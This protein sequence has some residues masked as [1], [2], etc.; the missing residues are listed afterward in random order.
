MRFPA[1]GPTTCVTLLRAS[2]EVLAAEDRSARH[3]DAGLVRF[4][5][6]GANSG[7]DDRVQPETTVLWKR[8]SH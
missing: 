1:A 7:G 8:R 3:E 5:H 6:C 4:K 2:L